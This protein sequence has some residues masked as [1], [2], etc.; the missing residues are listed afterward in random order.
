MGMALGQALG[1][2]PK[3][4]SRLVGGVVFMVPVGRA[5]ALTGNT[6]GSVRAP[7]LREPPPPWAP[8]PRVESELCEI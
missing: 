8:P 6:P 4:L 3:H 2:I 1:V 7:A 5:Q